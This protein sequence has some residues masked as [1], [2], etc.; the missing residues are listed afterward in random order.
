MGPC[1]TAGGGVLLKHVEADFTHRLRPQRGQ[2]FPA[3]R[4]RFHASAPAPTGPVVPSMSRQI[5]RVGSG[6]NGATLESPVLQGRIN[7]SHSDHQHHV[8]RRLR[9]RPTHDHRARSQWYPRRQAPRRR[10]VGRGAPRLPSMR[11]QKCPERHAARLG[12]GGTQQP[13][14]GGTTVRVPPHFFLR[15]LRF[16]FSLGG[17]DEAKAYGLSKHRWNSASSWTACPA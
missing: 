17:R 2:S 14:A 7:R 15:G 12:M 8:T 9:P 3:C 13:P 10:A 6:P 5:P 1:G 4:G 16:F 11:E